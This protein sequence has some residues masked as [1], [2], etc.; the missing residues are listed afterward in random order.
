MPSQK[1]SHTSHRR[2]NESL[3]EFTVADESVNLSQ[4]T[5]THSGRYWYNIHL[6]LVTQQ[7]YRTTD[8]TQLR[9]IRDQSFRI[10]A[11]KGHQIAALSV[12]PDHVHVALRGNI[13]H[14]PEQIA[15]A[16]MN[17][18][19]YALGQNAVWTFGYYVGTFSEYDMWAVRR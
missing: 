19:A 17:N 12:V 5:A 10:A 16:F 11:K 4:P 15:L 13:E 3:R 9:T 6:V 1:R 18:L 7:R 8:L 14:A 2:F